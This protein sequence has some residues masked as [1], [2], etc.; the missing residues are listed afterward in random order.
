MTAFIFCCLAL[1]NDLNR[2]TGTVNI[3][4][5]GQRIYGRAHSKQSSELW[6]FFPSSVD[7]ELILHA[8]WQGVNGQGGLLAVGDRVVIILSLWH[9]RGLREAMMEQEKMK[10]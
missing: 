10:D 2:L 7:M 5:V 3:D 9:E 8:S 6:S 4:A 1:Q